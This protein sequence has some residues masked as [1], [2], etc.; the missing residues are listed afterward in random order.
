MKYKKFIGGLLLTL[1]V[2]A[3]VMAACVWSYNEGG[4]QQLLRGGLLAMGFV[5]LAGV[6]CFTILVGAALFKS[7]DEKEGDSNS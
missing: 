3:P 4:W 1:S 5:L 6:W 7:E 2:L